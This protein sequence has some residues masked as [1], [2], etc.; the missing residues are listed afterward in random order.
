M[1]SKPRTNKTVTKN[2]RFSY[3]MLKQIAVALEAEN[4]RNFSAWVID[5]CRIKLSAYQPRKP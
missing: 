3:S 5:A 4:S 2:I 1:P